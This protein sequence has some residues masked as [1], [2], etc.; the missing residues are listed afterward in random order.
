M[1]ENESV[2]KNKVEARIYEISN[3]MHKLIN[4][5]LGTE[6]NGILH[7]G[8]GVYG[9]EYWFSNRIEMVDLNYIE[10]AIGLVPKTVICLGETELSKEEFERFIESDLLPKFNIEKYDMFFNNCNHFAD[11][12]SKYLVEK[13]LPKYVMDISNEVY[14]AMDKTGVDFSNKIARYVMIS[15]GRFNRKASLDKHRKIFN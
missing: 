7:V 3:G 12:V 9:C 6:I 15:W 1:V 8:I 11:D 10:K 5:L 14:N 2:E 13:P 4:K